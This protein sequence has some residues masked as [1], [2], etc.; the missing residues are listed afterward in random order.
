MA[1]FRPL[2]RIFYSYVGLWGEY[3]ARG[4]GGDETGTD[5]RSPAFRKGPDCV[6]FF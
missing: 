3:P 5:Y 1:S 6:A 4:G 2:F